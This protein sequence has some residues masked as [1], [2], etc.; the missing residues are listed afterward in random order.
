MVD[1]GMS[2]W[3]LPLNQAALHKPR[4]LCFPS[5]GGGSTMFAELAEIIG[6]G[7]QMLG[8]SLPGRQAR[9]TE[10]ACTDIGTLISSLA[11]AVGGRPGPPYLLFGYCSGALLAFLLA[12]ALRARA[13]AQ[14]SGLIVASYAAPDLVKVATYLHALP[15][16]DFWA[17]IL[18]YGG[19][20]V[21]IAVQPDMREIFEP[22]LRADYKLLANYRW[23]PSP[24]F[25]FPIAV[26]RGLRDLA[27]PVESLT[28]WSRHTR[29]PFSIHEMSGDH[30]LLAGC[31]EDLAAILASQAEA[32]AGRPAGSP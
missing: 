31:Q 30:W 17:E 7:V 3:F 8:L 26:A 28:A 21:E 12:Q 10:P 11:D 9:F 22:A 13:V 16:D 15:S 19:I 32:A 2:A 4:I 23:E 6:P 24:P 27:N 14:P 18:S 29:G 1:D 5:A 20:P 25:E